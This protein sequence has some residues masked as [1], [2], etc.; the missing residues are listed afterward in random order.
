MEGTVMGTAAYMSPE[1][2][3]HCQITFSV[4]P[5]PHME[6]FLVNYQSCLRPA[7]PGSTTR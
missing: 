7:T 5:L 3:A 2:A 1:Q 4:M 6:P